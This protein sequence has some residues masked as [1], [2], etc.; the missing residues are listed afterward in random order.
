MSDMDAVLIV[1]VLGLVTVCAVGL[2]VIEVR[3][4]LGAMFDD[5]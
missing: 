1:V 3:R 2:V 5:E 4:V